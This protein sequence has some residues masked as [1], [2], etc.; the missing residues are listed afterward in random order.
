LQFT[1][2][3]IGDVVEFSLE[4]DAVDFILIGVDFAGK[5]QEAV[6]QRPILGVVHCDL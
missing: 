1:E 6:G 2:E 5:V 3:E 4:E